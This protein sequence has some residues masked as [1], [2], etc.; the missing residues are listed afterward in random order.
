MNFLYSKQQLGSGRWKG[1][2]HRSIG[3]FRQHLR[4]II[5]TR[6]AGIF[7]NSYGGR[8]VRS[9]KT[10]PHEIERTNHQ[11]RPHSIRKSTY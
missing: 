9:W 7:S 1:F 4:R 8:F 10:I 2:E 6:Q 3:L 5:E 11:R